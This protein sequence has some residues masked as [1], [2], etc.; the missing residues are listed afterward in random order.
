MVRALAIVASLACLTVARPGAAQVE[1]RRTEVAYQL[2][3][4][5]SPGDDGK[6]VVMGYSIRSMEI[7]PRTDAPGQVLRGYLIAADVH[8]VVAYMEVT[9]WPGGG[10]KDRQL[11]PEWPQ[12][13]IDDPIY[14]RIGDPGRPELTDEKGGGRYA[15]VMPMGLPP[16]T[17]T[18]RASLYLALDARSGRKWK[19]VNKWLVNTVVE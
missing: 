6:P 7:V 13:A 14:R 8:P 4:P 2:V 10:P 5:F 18:V 11:K 1:D 19:H 12:G 9:V 16:G 15:F 3:D 17:Y